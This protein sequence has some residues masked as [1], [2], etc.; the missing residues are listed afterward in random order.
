MTHRFYKQDGK[1]YIHLPKYLEGGGKL[2]DLQMV[3]GAD[4]TLDELSNDGDEVYVNINIHCIPGYDCVLVKSQ[5]LAEGEGGCNYHTILP[6]RLSVEMSW[7]CPVTKF[8]FGKYPDV[9]F[10]KV[11]EK[12]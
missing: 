4:T 8:V 5:E 11:V 3:A 10:G 1:W 6:T 12:Q 9:I 7:L 2:E